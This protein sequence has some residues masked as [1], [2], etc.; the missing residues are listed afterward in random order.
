MYAMSE[1]FFS[2]KYITSDT[3]DCKKEAKL[4]PFRNQL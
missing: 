2:I 3:P 1:L 4:N